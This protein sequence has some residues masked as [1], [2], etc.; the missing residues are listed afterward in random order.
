MCELAG[1]RYCRRMTSEERVADYCPGCWAPVVD[2]VEGEKNENGRKGD[3]VNSSV[4][5]G[6]GSSPFLALLI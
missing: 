1:T 4:S 2:A 6:K 3:V 5:S